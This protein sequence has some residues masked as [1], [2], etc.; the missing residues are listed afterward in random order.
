MSSKTM[1]AV[2][3]ILIAVVA[4]ISAATILGDDPTDIPGPDGGTF[5]TDIPGEE[6]RFHDPVASDEEFRTSLELMNKVLRS[7]DS[8]IDE[9]G[10]AITGTYHDLLVM[11]ERYM[12]SEA[13]YYREPAKY[14]EAFSPWFATVNSAFDDFNR[15]IKEALTGDKGQKVESALESVGMD[16]DSY[17]EYDEMDPEQVSLLQ[18]QSELENE[19]A[20]IMGTEYSVQWGGRTWTVQSVLDS[21]TLTSE[22]KGTVLDM[23]YA[24]QYTDA[25]EVYIELVSVLNDFAGYYGYEDY[26]DYAYGNVYHR[27]YA[28]EDVAGMYDCVETNVEMTTTLNDLLFGESDLFGSLGYIKDYGYEELYGSMETV[29]DM[30]GTEYSDL[31]G[32]MDRNGLLMIEG[33][34]GQ[35]GSCYTSELRAHHSALMLM[36]DMGTHNQIS[37]IHEFGHAANMCLSERSNI[38]F[39]VCEINSQGLECLSLHLL[40]ELAPE[41]P[42]AYATM[43][44]GNLSYQVVL[45]SM[46]TEFELWAFETEASGTELTVDSLMGK[47]ESITDRWG[48]SI[49]NGVI[50]DGYIWADVGHLFYSP[51]Y[52]ISYSTSALNSM[53]IMLTAEEDFEKAKGMYLAT[54]EQDGR[55]G[56]VETVGNAGLSNVLV[57]GN[58]LRISAEMSEWVKENYGDPASAHA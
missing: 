24:L 17:R 47:F 7:P 6:R 53:E 26:A 36:S 28:P 15:S 10:Y 49:S 29:A 21:D 37:A 40:D 35:I 2:A 30:L 20:T 52:Y 43:V 31:L 1:A 9:M 56:Y 55:N 34:E 13:F 25:I 19:Y 12:W 23:I 11:E 4:A 22:E 38:C 33:I 50:D 54:M 16:A 27:D 8:G 32:Y 42:D 5:P 57:D 44:I 39:D 58:A 46:L 14:S 3:V 18:R 45:G 51:M 48:Y 41:A